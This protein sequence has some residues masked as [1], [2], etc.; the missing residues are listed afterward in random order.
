MS[1]SSSAAF[2]ALAVNGLSALLSRFRQ[3]PLFGFEL[4]I[5]L[6]AL[7]VVIVVPLIALLA[8]SDLGKAA[9]TRE[10]AVANTHLFYGLWVIFGLGVVIVIFVACAVV[11]LVVAPPYLSRFTMGLLS[12]VFVAIGAVLAMNLLVPVIAPRRS[13]MP[14]RV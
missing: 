11:A 10:L 4:T 3:L 2:V 8:L 9:L 13:T 1:I 14:I 7:T 5:F 12:V 6:T